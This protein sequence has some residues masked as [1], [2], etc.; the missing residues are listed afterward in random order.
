MGEVYKARDIRLD[1]FVAVK[2]SKEQFSERFEREARAVAALNHP[3]ICTLYDVGPNYL[4]MEYIEGEPLKGPIPAKKAIEFS[5]QILDALDAAHKKGIVHHD[6]KPANIL[7]TKQ[8]IKLLDFGLASRAPSLGSDSETATMTLTEVGV[9]MGTPA[10]MAPEQWEGNRGDARSDIYAFGCVLYEMLTGKS[11]SAERVP[12]E[13]VELE[14]VLKTCLAKDPEDRWQSAGDLK[15]HV[16]GILERRSRP[17]KYA[18]A[19]AATVLVVV[20]GF[21]LL[22]Q[23]IRAAPLTDKDVLVLA[24][25]TNNTGD[26]VFDGTL[27]EALAIHLE[28]SPFL[29]IL[30]DAQVRQDLQLMSR[31]P[32]ERITNDIAHE[33]CI[34]EREKAMVGG[35]IASLGKTYAITLQATNCQTGETLAREQV[36]AE[37]K[38]YVIQSVGAAAKGMRVKLGES[39]S[40]IQKLDLPAMKVTTSSLEALQTF[41]LGIDQFRL[42]LWLSAIP[43]FRRATELDPNFAL[44]FEVMASAYSNAG[45]TSRSI[46]YH[47]KA[48][49]L[50]DRVSER[51]RLQIS[52]W[53]YRTATGELN[54]AADVVQLLVQTYP[55]DGTA[56]VSGGSLYRGLGEFEKTAQYDEE[57]VRLSPRGSVTYGNLMDAY[58]LLG[59]FDEVRTI[60][61]KAFAQKLDA[62]LIHQNLLWVANMQGDRAAIEREIRWFAG[63][64]DEPRSLDEQGVYA[65]VL[66]QPRKAA[67]LLRRGA[68]LLR[69]Q[70]LNGAA[71]TREQAAAADPYGDCGADV[72]GDGI[73]SCGD[74]DGELKAAEARLKVRPAD[75]LL[76]SVELPTLAATIKLKQ[77]QPDEAIELLQSAAPYERRYVQPVYLRGMAY[78]RL[79]RGA[80]AAAEFQKIIDHK[81]PYWG[82]RYALSYLGLA[83]AATLAGDVR[84]ATKAYQDF[85]NLWKDADPDISLLIQAKKEYAALN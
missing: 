58:A 7:V 44:G 36:V 30:D 61:E 82:S 9:L 28:E 20:T 22:Q 62:P 37:D 69:Q 42:G 70:D 21:L 31:R 83:R 84:R 32:D 23:R 65:V 12:L 19:T 6:L 27:R 25:F 71:R 41:S 10:Y 80:E 35:A 55:R 43:F 53:Y 16:E 46:E 48:F 78:L 11:I 45:E 67:E 26:P 76:R 38:E 17:W 64:V 51:E 3:H 59:R 5:A 85:F 66:G 56:R 81:A 13:L 63:K 47:K 77:N 15:R 14:N 50:I 49:E 2:V 72:I 24:E 68:R 34:R 79:G 54:K 52:F 8:G 33:I 60:A 73:L 75:T 18:A 40:S 74:L 29:K 4:V 57:A 39:L 1:R